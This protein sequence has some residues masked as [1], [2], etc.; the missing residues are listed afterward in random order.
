MNDE[1]LGLMGLRPI[2]IDPM[3][4]MGFK[5]SNFQTGIRNARRE[6]TG[7]PEGLLKGGP[8]TPMDVV[9]RYFV[10]NKALFNFA[11]ACSKTSSIG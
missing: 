2:S 5:I 7:G 6:F 10:A 1:V 11:T 3:D 4:A 9:E 8:K